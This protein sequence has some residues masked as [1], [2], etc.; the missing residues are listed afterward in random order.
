MHPVYEP[1]D[2]HIAPVVTLL[3]ENGFN[4]F[5]SCDGGPGHAFQ[6]PTV[7][8]DPVMAEV[9]VEASACAC[10]LLKAGYKG[11]YVKICRG[12]GGV[13]QAGEGTMDSFIEVEFWTNPPVKE[14]D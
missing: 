2:P 13:L 4:T 3:R 14:D 9:E 7:R 6:M 5:T 8:I 12:Y 11:F 10:S 1:L